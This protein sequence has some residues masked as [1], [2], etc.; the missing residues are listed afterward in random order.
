MQN[1]LGCDSIIT[2]HL[3]VNPISTNILNQSICAGDA[4]VFNG[5]SLTVG[6]TYKDTLQNYLGCDSITT[7]TLT[8]NPLPSKATTTSGATITAT[9]TS[10]TYQWIDCATNVPI[11]GAT[12]RNYTATATGDYAVIVTVGS[13]FDTSSCVNIIISGIESIALSNIKVYPNPTSNDVKIDFGA[14]ISKGNIKVYNTIGAIVEETKIENQNISTLHVANYA[15]G[16]YW[17]SIQI[18]NQTQRLKIVK[19]D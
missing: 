7:L 10:A 18:N 12:A 8:V 11:S 3:T 15:N 2:L 6:G 4:Y 1:Y 13:C 17:L 5:H 19:Q 9:Q 16:V 14:L